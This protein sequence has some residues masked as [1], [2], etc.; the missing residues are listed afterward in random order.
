MICADDDACLMALDRDISNSAT[1]T[2]VDRAA[3]WIAG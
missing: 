3:I 1:R 2:A